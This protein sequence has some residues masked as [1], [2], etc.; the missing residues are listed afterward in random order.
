MDMDAPWAFASALEYLFSCWGGIVVPKIL[1]IEGLRCLSYL[2]T[3]SHNAC[4]SIR[5][6]DV[7]AAKA[8]M[9]SIPLLGLCLL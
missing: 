9:S 7:V 1:V 8:C 3:R 5:G 6:V 4:N 2:F